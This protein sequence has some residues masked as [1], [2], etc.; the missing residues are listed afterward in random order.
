M[1]P[2]LKRNF[3]AYNTLIEGELTYFGTEIKQLNTES[4]NLKR[5]HGNMIWREKVKAGKSM[6]RGA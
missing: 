3:K 4:S 6:L 2:V 5:M 1:F